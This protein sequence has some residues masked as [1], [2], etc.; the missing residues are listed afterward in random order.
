[1][2]EVGIVSRVISKNVVEI[3]AATKDECDKCP[4]ASTCPSHLSDKGGTILAWN[5]IGAQVGDLVEYEYEEKDILRGIF[6]V[7]MIPFFY[8][9]IGLFVG[10]VLEKVFNIHIG[11]LENLLTVLVTLVFLTIGIFSVR[12]KD[13][14]FR[15]PSRVVT[16]LYKNPGF[17]NIEPVKKQ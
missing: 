3:R 2:R 13:K 6:T 4:L 14:N 17:V 5:E 11:H 1:M 9:L 16:V 10:F 12:E 7:Y 8:F 15:I